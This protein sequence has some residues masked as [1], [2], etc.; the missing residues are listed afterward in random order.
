MIRTALCDLLDIEHPIIQAGMGTSTSAQL[1]AAVSNAGALGSIGNLL[2]SASDLK[3]QLDILRDLTARPYALNHTVP[4]LDEEAFQIS[5][6][7]RPKLMSFALAH[8][9]DY[10]RRAHD[11]GVL[12]MHQ[13]TTVE[14]AVQAA[15]AGTDIIVAQGGES[16]GYSGS[17]STI[18]LVPQ[19]VDAVRP[20]PV[21]AAGGIYD[22][23]GLAAALMLGAVGVNIGTRFL[24]SKEAPI[25]E[26]Y[27][28]LIASAGSG[29]TVQ[30]TAF[31]RILPDLV[32]GGYDVALRSIS[33][34]FTR[35]WEQRLGEVNTQRE[36]LLEQFG[37]A[38]AAGRLH[39]LIA[40]AG[41]SSG[42]ITG[43]I[44]AGDIVAELVRGAEEAL[45]AGLKVQ[46][47][48]T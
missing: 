26:A 47:D 28:H 1:A 9:G 48:R 36:T 11:A 27:K 19:V 23:R 17:I 38:G 12:V 41:Q 24:A 34:D 15:E 32:R 4:T 16:G 20:L 18:V 44:P 39:E 6:D 35:E 8:P 42:G 7:A 45:Q 5:L 40:P 46:D 21:V 43:I 2:R 13:V 30:F 14:E 31:N 22:G 3:R 25:P 29:D 33:T 10:I 37:E